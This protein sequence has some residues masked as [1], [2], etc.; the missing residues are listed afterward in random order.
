MR[1]T[2][3]NIKTV[4]VPIGAG[5]DGQTALAIAQIIA[6]EVILVG[7]VPIGKDASISAGAQEARMVRKRLLSL[8]SGPSIR[9]KS[10]VIVSE[11]PWEDLKSVIANEKP[12]LLMIEW[13]KGQISSSLSISDILSNSLCNIAIVRGAKPVKFGESFNCG[14]W[15]SVCRAGIPDG[16][17]ITVRPNGCTASC[18]DRRSK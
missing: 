2:T 10:T 16:Y 13:E 11:T 5:T 7:I 9:F 17:G 6:R 14:T 15:W 4:L 1:K 3:R 8:S 18:P 12:D